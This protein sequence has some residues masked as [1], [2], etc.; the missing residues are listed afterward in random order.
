MELNF[1]QSATLLAAITAQ[2]TGR[3]ALTA[4]NASEFVSVGTTALSVGYDNLIGAISQVLSKTIFTTRPYTRKFKGLTATNIQYGNHVRKLSV[5]DDDPETNAEYNLTDGDSVD[6]YTVKKPKIVQ[7]NF[8]NAAT[9]ERYITIYKHQLDVAFSN[10]AEFAA[11]I[12]MVVQNVSD[13][14]EQDHETCS[15]FTLCNFIGGKIKGDTSNVIHLVTEYNAASGAQL[16][17]ATVRKPENFVPFMKWAM[18]RIRNVSQLMSERTQMFHVNI[19]GKPISR[20]TPVDKQRVYLLSSDVN[21]MESTVLS[22]V[23]H[24]E[25]LK[26]VD[27]EPVSFWQSVKNPDSI[28]ITASYMSANGDI[29]T[30]A[31]SQSN[32]FGVIFDQEAMGVTTVNTWTAHTPL[33]AKGGFSNVYWHFTDRYWNDFTENGVVLLLD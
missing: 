16:T 3:A 2:A 14:I 21:M 32:V 20:H 17:A 27:F 12:S 31:V 5:V 7:T 33:N 13:Q 10:A 25:Y 23:F 26:K 30:A 18:A 4:T 1:N 15:R 29:T 19:E 22:S 28:N 6:H 9:Y 8:Y 24:D 11:F